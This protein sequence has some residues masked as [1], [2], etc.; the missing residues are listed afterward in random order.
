MSLD[1]KETKTPGEK[2]RKVLHRG[3]TDVETQQEDRHPQGKGR[4]W[5]DLLS[6]F[7]RNQNS[8][9][10]ILAYNGGKPNPTKPPV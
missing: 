10:D 1:K 4:Q 8:N 9:L 7:S 5:T 2:Q 3:T 6:A